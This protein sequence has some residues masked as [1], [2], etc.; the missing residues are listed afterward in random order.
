MGAIIHYEVTSGEEDLRDV[1]KID[2][3]FVSFT[4]GL[5]LL[6]NSFYAFSLLDE[7]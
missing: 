2:V 6:C 5:R 7:S 3:C 1:S 4:K